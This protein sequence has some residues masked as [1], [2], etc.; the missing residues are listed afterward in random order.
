MAWNHGAQMV[1]QNMQGLGKELWQAHGKFRGNGGCGYILKPKFLLE[2]SPTGEVFNPLKFKQPEIKFKVKAMMTLGW[3]KA[4]GKRHFD[5]FSPPDFFTRVLVSEVPADVQKW[6]TS[7]V[8]DT[9]VPHWNEEHVFKLKVPE[10][11]LLRLVVRD[12]DEESQDEFEGQTCLPI[13][14]IRDGYR[15][16]HYIPI[17]HYLHIPINHKIPIVTGNAESSEALVTE[18]CSQ[19][20]DMTVSI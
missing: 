6:K 15:C 5:L 10:L 3:D 19:F 9:W 11:A 4:F 13:H 2:N 7:V 17:H 20:V 14:E 18:I 16:V 1:A 12:H 8:D